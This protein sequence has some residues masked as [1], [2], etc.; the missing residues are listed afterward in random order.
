VAISFA[1]PRISSAGIPDSEES[2]CDPKE[3][4][5]MDS[6]DTENC[7]PTF[8]PADVFLSPGIPASNSKAN[9]CENPQDLTS[10]LPTTNFDHKA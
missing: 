2:A 6:E 4:L 9:D 8:H 3:V 1:P 7:R 10:I 5:V